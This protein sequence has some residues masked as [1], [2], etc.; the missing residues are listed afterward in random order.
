[1]APLRGLLVSLPI[2]LSLLI[3]GIRVEERHA[4]LRR[5]GLR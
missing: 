5:L 4:D 2:R 3:M 1:A